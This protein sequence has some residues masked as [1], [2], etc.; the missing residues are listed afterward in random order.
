MAKLKMKYIEIAAPIE[1]GKDI[2]D[3]L[4]MR[5]VI[6]LHEQEETEGLDRLSSG[7]TVSQ[8]EKYMDTFFGTF[9][10]RPSG[11]GA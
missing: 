6:E 10:P 3:F 5:S 7:R 11:R 2:F 4:Q 8:F 1:Q 9:F